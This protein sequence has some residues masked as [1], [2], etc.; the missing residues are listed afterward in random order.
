MKSSI[1]CCAIVVTLS[2]SA[3]RAV[4]GD[5][6]T[7]SS[8]PTSTDWRVAGNWMPATVPN[9][10]SCVASFG[11]SALS[12]VEMF[13]SNGHFFTATVAQVTFTPGASA[14]TITAH[15]LRAVDFAGAG[16]VNQSGIQQHFTTDA[17]EGHPGAAQ[18]I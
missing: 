4:Y 14:Y 6:A 17:E 5:S 2:V 11:A 12:Q 15:G 3:L 18:F 9:C 10:G 1:L 13:G 8:N 16:G 7:W